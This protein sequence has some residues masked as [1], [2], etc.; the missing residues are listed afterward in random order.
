[1]LISQNKK[2]S[3]VRWLL[4]IMY[5]LRRV[6]RNRTPKNRKTLTYYS[7]YLFTVNKLFA[8]GEKECIIICDCKDECAIL[9]VHLLCRRL[10]LKFTVQKPISAVKFIIHLN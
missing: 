1:M 6:H 7:I 5:L 8:I 2:E 4:E 9:A 10:N 3:M